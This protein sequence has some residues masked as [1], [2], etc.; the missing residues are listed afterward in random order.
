VCVCV[1]VCV[2]VRVCIYM[3]Y[4]CIYHMTPRSG[5][6]STAEESLLTNCRFP[7]VFFFSFF[8]LPLDTLLHLEISRY[9][10]D[11]MSLKNMMCVY[12]YIL[13]ISDYMREG[14]TSVFVNSHAPFSLASDML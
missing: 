14:I 2:C 11:L 7:K 10:S 13:V 9:Q 5:L 8:L 3:L 12:I 4:I 6:L 1:C